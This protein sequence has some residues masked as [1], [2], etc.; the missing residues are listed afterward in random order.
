MHT[1]IDFFYYIP[2]LKLS[3]LFWFL[4][5]IG[6]TPILFTLIQLVSS[7][8]EVILFYVATYLVRKLGHDAVLYMG[9]WVYGV[10]YLLYSYIQHPWYVI[11][12][13]SLQ[14][15]TYGLVWT[16]SV[17]YITSHPGI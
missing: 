10:K 11:P 12:I 4:Q 17:S 8:S 3:F 13:E 5:D 14:G 6:G 15:V 1:V 9:L 2:S 7:L 16:A